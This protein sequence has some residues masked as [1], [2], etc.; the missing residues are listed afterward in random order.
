MDLDYKG[1]LYIA[2][3]FL[4]AL[5]GSKFQQKSL[6]AKSDDDYNMDQDEGCC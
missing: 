4:L 5:F 6:K 2:A 3:F 1:Y